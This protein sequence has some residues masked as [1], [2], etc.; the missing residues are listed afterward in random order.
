MSSPSTA[1]DVAARIE[2]EG[3]DALLKHCHQALSMNNA[4]LL[5]VSFATLDKYLTQGGTLPQRWSNAQPP[6]PGVE[7]ANVMVVSGHDAPETVVLDAENNITVTDKRG[8][9]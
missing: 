2:T 9:R 5:A 3:G 4:S 6:D 1:A 7:I 8:R